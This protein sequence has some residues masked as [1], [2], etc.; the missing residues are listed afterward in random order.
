MKKIILTTIWGIVGFISGVYITLGLS[1]VSAAFETTPIN[2]N[3][4][5]TGTNSTST[6]LVAT[7]LLNSDIVGYTTI[8]MTPN[9]ANLLLTLPASST[10]STWLPLAGNAV[11]FYLLNAT[12]TAGVN[13][14]LYPGIGTLIQQAS[15]TATTTSQRYSEIK[16]VRKPNTD[17]LFMII[18]A[19]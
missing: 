12:T 10:L 19:V 2:P 1:V 6:P 3:P 11:T 7:T 5:F 14:G 9:T 13:I 4:I 15:T 8:S 17:L 18:P 16:V